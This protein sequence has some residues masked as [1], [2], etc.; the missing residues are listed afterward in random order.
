MRYLL[1]PSR[2]TDTVSEIGTICSSHVQFPKSP[3][4]TT[5]EALSTFDGNIL[6]GLTSDLVSTAE[7]TSGAEGADRYGLHSQMRIH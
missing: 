7:L 1:K 5:G 3:N 6:F 4:L 2:I